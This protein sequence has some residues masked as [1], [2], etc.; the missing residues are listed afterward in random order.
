MTSIN[1][2][3][4]IKMGL[5]KLFPHYTIHTLRVF[6]KLINWCNKNIV[7]NNTP[8]LILWGD[9]DQLV[10]FKSIEFV[11]NKFI[12]SKV[13]VYDDITHLMLNG[14]NINKIVRDILDFLV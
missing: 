10:P 1:N 13:I 5:F 2:M 6:S 12:E 9:L 11:S 7:E 8:C 4:A 3:K 14:I